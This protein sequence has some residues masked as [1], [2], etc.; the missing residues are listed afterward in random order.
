[1]RLRNI[2]GAE[3]EVAKSPYCITTPQEYR[4]HW[5]DVF[6]NDNP[7]YIEIGMGKGRFIINNATTYPDI[8]FIGIEK[9][10]SVQIRAVQKLREMED[11]P[12]LRLLSI[13]AEILPEIF[14]EGEISRIYLNFSDPWPK[15]RHA[16]R[17][18][19]SGE[20][21]DRYKKV[22]KSGDLVEFKT[23]NKG[24]FE[25][26]LEEIE[27]KG[28]ILD[29]KTDNLHRDQVMGEGNIMTEYEV[30]FMK[31]DKPIY[32]LICHF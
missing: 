19:T 28:W 15:E 13:N 30:K 7:I 4:G 21:L 31:L 3:E 11:I 2:P 32:K 20:F 14:D 9:Y 29:G 16:K 23:D 24:L 8:N 10:P 1:M 18:L 6:K 12:N 25:F 5:A 22:L 17:R 26:S 27:E